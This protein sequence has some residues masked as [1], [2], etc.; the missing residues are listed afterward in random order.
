MA[1]VPTVDPG[2]FAP[3]LADAV[4]HPSSADRVRLGALPAW[5]VRPELAV[6]FVSF[7]RRDR[8]SRRVIGTAPGTGT[9]ARGV[10]QSLSQLHGRAIERGDRRWYDR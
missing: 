4:G 2:D 8:W 6:A 9:P 3:E 10:L 7:Q 1:R 5:A